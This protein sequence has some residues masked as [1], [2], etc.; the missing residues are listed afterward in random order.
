MVKIRVPGQG[1]SCCVV[2][3]VLVSNVVAK[4]YN[5]D[6]EKPQKNKQKT[7]KTF[8]KAHANEL[9]PCVP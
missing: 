1:L 5:Q 3:T 6:K 7:Q 8:L 4:I 9:W 2:S